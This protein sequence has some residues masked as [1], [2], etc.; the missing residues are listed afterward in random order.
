[1]TKILEKTIID[2]T[3]TSSTAM[4][5]NLFEE[6]M[7][8]GAYADGHVC[9]V[10]GK[11][12]FTP[13][14]MSRLKSLAVQHNVEIDHIYTSAVQTQLAGLNSGLLVA[15][16]APGEQI[17]KEFKESIN[18]PQAT[19]MKV[20]E[21]VQQQDGRVDL[22]TGVVVDNNSD[23]KDSEIFSTT[24]QN[25]EPEHKMMNDVV[26]ILNRD[27]EMVQQKINLPFETKI[28]ISEEVQKPVQ[29]EN[30]E[31][32]TLYLHQ[33]LRSGQIISHKG[34]III[35][36][37]T[38]PGSEV[39]AGGDI[40]VWGTLGGIAHA[41]VYGNYKASIRALKLNAIQ[42]RIAD[43]IA[44]RP[45]FNNDFIKEIPLKPEVARISNGEIKIFS[46]K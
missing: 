2:L 5:L 33:T 12:V 42:I 46:L 36:G 11:L 32:T 43:Y 7:Q 27:S 35:A 1:M 45:D 19:P 3:S 17:L 34:H 26:E 6:K 41:G 40:I 16:I 21:E 4:A 38:H 39:I 13:G 8:T 20:S 18:N 24:Q 14:H 31:I 37:D 28:D 29:A 44:R 30:E 9:V 23:I 15:E 10:L 25:K 22:S